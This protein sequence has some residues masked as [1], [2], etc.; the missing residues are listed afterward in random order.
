MR[1]ENISLRSIV[2]RAVA[3]VIAV[4]G[5]AVAQDQ[6]PAM[7]MTTPIP[8]E[9][10]TP[11]AV[12][13][14][15]GD[16]KFSD[17][18]PDQATIE[19][20]YDN[21][22][23][24]RGV[25]VF[26]NT[27]SGASLVAFRRGLR[28]VGCVGGT[29]GIFESL[30]DS[31]TLLLTPNTD[32]IY[33]TTWLDLKNGPVVIEVPPNVLGLVD[34]FWFHYVV[35]LGGVGPDHGK[36]GKYLFLPPGYKGAVPQ[37]YFVVRPATYGSW[38]LWR[39]FTV[40]GDPKPA[41]ESM[42][43]NTHIYALS[44]A[45]NPPQQKF[46]NLSGR[47]FNTIGANTFKFY[48][49]VNEIVQEEPSEALEPELLGQLAAVGIV[50][51]KPFA[52]DDRMKGILTDSVAVGNATARALS[53]RPRDQ[54]QY[55]YP[56]KAWSTPFVGGSY[57]FLQ[58][59]ARLLDPRAVFFYNA[60]GITPAMSMVMVGKGSQYAGAFV[61]SKQN[62]LDGSKTYKLTLP[63]NVPAADFWSFVAYDTQTR[64]E[65]QTD[66]QFPGVGS[67]SKGLDKNPDGSFD[68]Y[69]G[70]KAPA[71]KENNWIQTVPGKSWFTILRLYGPQQSWFDKT[72]RPG[73]IE[74]L[75]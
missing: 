64:S 36:G 63:A 40:N 46:V 21:L 29:L 6:P 48:E 60:T 16:L 54:R 38:L 68:I 22:D 52:P 19:K 2:S 75:N 72:W 65:L 34:D 50:K 31:K 7:K 33:A 74:V 66:Q 18:E 20:V 12:R 67:N 70:P 51:G 56:G 49:D 47:A 14:R 17:G 13:T 53:A 43:K 27:M 41:V 44:E 23:F 45:A 39:G 32:S 11:A 69:F 4:A 10:T 61:D 26:L 35:D 9:I 30:M 55:F 25:D 57:L 59:G 37:G 73:E 3:M 58:D 5:L 28:E 24:Q 71:G 1:I 15:I 62:Y 8:A 42:R